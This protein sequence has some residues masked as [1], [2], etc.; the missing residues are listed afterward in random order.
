MEWGAMPRTVLV[1]DDQALPRQALAGELADAGFAVIEAADGEEAWQRFSESVP[2]VVVTD[3]VMPKSDGL[4]LLSR[5][6][7]RSEV[8]VILFTARGSIQNAT[9]AMKAGAQ[10]FVASPDVALDELVQLVRDAAERPLSNSEHPDLERRFVGDSRALKRLRERLA[11]LASLRTPV[12]VCG[13]AGSGRAAAVAALHELGVSSGGN[14]VRLSPDAPRLDNRLPPPAAV[15]LA[16][17][18]EFPDAAQR[19]WTERLLAAERDDWKRGPRVFASAIDAPA[20]LAK[21]SHFE[22]GPGRAL[23]RFAVELPPLRTIREDIPAIARHL[24]LQVGI[25]LGRTIGLSPAAQQLLADQ[26]WRGNAAELARLLERAIT[27][28]RGR[29]IRRELVADLLRELEEDIGTLRAQ[30]AA[31][32]R[33]QLIRALRETGGNIS[34]SAEILNRSRSAIYRLIEKYEIRLTRED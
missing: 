13:E 26:R 15:F 1:V 24:A 21:D 17:I 19:D 11:G 16:G 14:L 20:V 9:A 12:L 33:D 6:R 10:E 27:F 18:D 23:L 25:R 22:R 32:E 7:E 5:I 4:E 3:L 31:R 29:Q 34:R 28:S 2:D 8:P 30:R